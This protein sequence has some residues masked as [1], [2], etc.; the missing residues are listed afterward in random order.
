M[1]EF[2]KYSQAL[3]QGKKARGNEKVL[4]ANILTYTIIRK[5]CRECGLGEFVYLRQCVSK[6]WGF[7]FLHISCVCFY[8]I[9]CCFHQR[10]P[11]VPSQQLHKRFLPPSLVQNLLLLMPCFAFLLLLNHPWL[12]T[13][14]CLILSHSLSHLASSHRLLN[15]HLIFAFNCFLFCHIL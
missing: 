10:P 6:S 4:L 15:I 1:W 5:T 3:V 12:L 13:S 2:S 8:S 14:Y 11:P 9:P 7:A